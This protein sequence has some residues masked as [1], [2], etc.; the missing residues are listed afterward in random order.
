MLARQALLQRLLTWRSL[1]TAWPVMQCPARPL[2][3]GLRCLLSAHVYPGSALTG[4]DLV[5][6]TMPSWLWVDQQ[7]V[8][9]RLHERDG[10]FVSCTV[11]VKDVWPTHPEHQERAA[12]EAHNLFCDGYG[13]QT[14]STRPP[15]SF[16]CGPPPK[17]SLS[18]LPDPP[19]VRPL[20]FPFHSSTHFS[21]PI[22]TYWR[23]DNT[24]DKQ[25]A[26]LPCWV[27][28]CVA[29]ST[30]PLAPSLPRPIRG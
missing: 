25:G 18:A 24:T 12:T 2:S 1:V 8:E 14:F 5:A 26:I 9:L 20:A 19:I 15:R 4:F 7:E 6:C 28:G 22:I 29:W 16:T 30:V 23:V 11:S 13:S 10:S 17:L 21:F 27:S 3:R